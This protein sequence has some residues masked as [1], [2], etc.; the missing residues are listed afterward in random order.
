MGTLAEPELTIAGGAPIHRQI[1]D[2][3]RDYILAGGLYPGEQLPT[4]RAVAVGLAV[5]PHAVN[6]AYTQ[7]EQE[8]FLSSEGGSGTFVAPLSHLRFVRAERA[9]RLERL[10]SR[11]LARA[12]RIGFSAEEVLRTV[13]AL[14]PSGERW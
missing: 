11:W 5:N 8:G 10:C 4:P 14:T 9:A 7:L 1:R 12:A 2:Q 6:Q 3:I 13:H